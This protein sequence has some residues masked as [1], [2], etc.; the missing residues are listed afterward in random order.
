MMLLVITGIIFKTGLY[1]YISFVKLQEN[2]I[3]IKCFVQERFILATF[4]YIAVYMLV[5]A[6]SLPGVAFMSMTGGVLFG[7]VFGFINA[8]TGAVLGSFIP[9]FS[10]RLAS[11]DVLETRVGSLARKMQKGFQHHALSYLLTL[12]LI[13]IFPFASINLVA[14]LMQL[15]FKTFFIGTFFGTIPATL[16]FVSMGVAVQEAILTTGFSCD[17]FMQYHIW[18]SLTGLGV[19]AVIPIIYKKLYS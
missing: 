13:P 18:G 11:R 19:L 4:M 1:R 5:V 6:L 9:F 7:Y 10:A 2:Y 3:P 12:R 14:A 8:I 15:S 16:I 17:M